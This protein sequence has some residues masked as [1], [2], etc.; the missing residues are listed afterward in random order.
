MFEHYPAHT[1]ER[2]RKFHTENPGV[3]EEF[4]RLAFEMKGNGRTRYSAETIINVIRWH[5]DLHTRG[6]VFE[7]NNDFKSIYVRLL[8]HRH[9]EFRDFFELRQVRSRGLKS[10]EQ[11]LREAQ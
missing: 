1:L 9:P 6:D 3:Y 2:F 11:Q 5:R 7:I 8:I 10:E 4:K